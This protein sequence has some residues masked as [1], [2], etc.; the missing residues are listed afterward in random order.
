[1]PV[2]LEIPP[3]WARCRKPALQL[4]WSLAGFLFVAI[5][6]VR[7]IRQQNM[8]VL[9]AG[10][11]RYGADERSLSKAKEWD[12]TAFQ[13]ESLLIGGGKESD[14]YLKD[15]GLELNHA[16][17][18]A[19]K[20]DSGVL[21]LL[22]PLGNIRKGYRNLSAPLPLAHGDS[23]QMGKYTFQFLSDTGE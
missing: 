9:V 8:P 18:N 3:I 16:R 5:V 7:R 13:K 15:A 14:L 21:I 4:G 22:E 2:Y 20:T 19:E 23:F 11:L 12:L 6:V 17:I 10:T 1:M